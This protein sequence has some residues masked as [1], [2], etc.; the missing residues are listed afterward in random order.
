[1]PEVNQPMT[2]GKLRELLSQFHE[3]DLVVV[4]DGTGG[5]MYAVVVDK[6]ATF[7]GQRVVIDPG[8]FLGHE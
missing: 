8:A 4:G 6:R 1:M 3:S 5:S 7:A 2:V